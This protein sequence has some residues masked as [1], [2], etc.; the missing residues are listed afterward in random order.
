MC[1]NTASLYPADQLDMELFERASD[2]LNRCG[3]PDKNSVGSAVRT[4]KGIFTGLDLKSR[5]TP[6]CAEP[7]AISAAYSGGAVNLESI[8]AVCMRGD[9]SNIV[10]ISPCGACRELINFHAPDCRVLFQYEKSWIDVQARQLFRYPIIFGLP[11][12][13]SGQYV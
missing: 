1:A 3:K 10:A 6:I 9:A 11:I 7:C 8:I 2:V 12:E 4:D 13:R 5:K